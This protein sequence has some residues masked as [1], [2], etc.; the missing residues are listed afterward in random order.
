MK[1]RDARDRRRLVFTSQLTG[2]FI[3]VDSET[4]KNRLAVPDPVGNH[5]TAGHLGAQWKAVC[6][7]DQW[8]ARRLRPQDG[9]PPFDGS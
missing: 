3:A 8:H 7:S 5:W 9:R 6:D 1:R 2:E 4:G